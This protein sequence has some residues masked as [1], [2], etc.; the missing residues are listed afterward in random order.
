MPRFTKTLRVPYGPDQ[1]FALV[2]DI[3]AYPRFIKWITALRVSEQREAGPGVN[4]CLGEVVVGFKGFTERFSTRV[5]ADE[6]AAR[7]TAALVRGPFRKL[8]A[9]WRITE[10]VAGAS[11]VSLEINYEFRNPVIGFLAAANHD[12]AVD[13]ILS[14]FLEEARRRYSAPLA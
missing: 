3:A 4:E 12:L 13:R 9:E 7:V 8:F 5:V 2:S 6:P 14:A 1:C 11:D 10:S